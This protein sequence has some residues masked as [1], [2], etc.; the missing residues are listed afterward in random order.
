M[1]R[2]HLFNHTSTR[3]RCIP[4]STDHG[5]TRDL[6]DIFLFLRH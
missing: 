3:H 2:K 1:I 5:T 4:S 6:Y